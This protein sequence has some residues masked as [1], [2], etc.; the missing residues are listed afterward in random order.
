MIVGCKYCCNKPGDLVWLHCVVPVSIIPEKYV[1]LLKLY[2]KD[3]NKNLP[4]VDTWA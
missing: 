4:H 3:S 2:D 1:S